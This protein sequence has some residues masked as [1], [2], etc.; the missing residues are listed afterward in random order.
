MDKIRVGDHPEKPTP[1]GGM[2]RTLA[3]RPELRL[4][5]LRVPAGEK[6]AE[7]TAPV[8]VIFLAL[9][10]QGTIYAGSESTTI[11]AG[12]VICCPAGIIR[13]LTA[14]DEDLELLVIRAPN[15]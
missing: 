2:A 10:G 4:V 1:L 8:E 9:A 11:T 6:V 5:V 3:N 15:L 7:H 14:D 12:E 13:S